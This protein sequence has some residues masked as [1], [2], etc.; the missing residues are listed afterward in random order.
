MDHRITNEWRKHGCTW[1]FRLA[2]QDLRHHKE[3]NARMKEKTTAA[4]KK[5]KPGWKG[6]SNT[7]ANTV[8]KCPPEE[9]SEPQ[10]TV[11]LWESTKEDPFGVAHAIE[12]KCSWSVALGSCGCCMYASGGRHICSW[13]ASTDE[14]TLSRDPRGLHQLPCPICG[15]TIFCLY[16]QKQIE[17]LLKLKHQV[18]HQCCERVK[19]SLL[20]FFLHL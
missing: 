8:V 12:L 16:G 9:P 6:C 20:L 13:G 10:E 5:K 3:V 4:L 17:R 11:V 2:D 14:E 1:F 19:L 18:S 7:Y 15:D